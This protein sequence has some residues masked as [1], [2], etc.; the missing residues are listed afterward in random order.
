MKKIQEN[1]GNKKGSPHRLPSIELMK[2]RTN[3]TSNNR[4]DDTRRYRD[5]TIPSLYG[6]SSFYTNAFLMEWK[7]AV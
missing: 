2:K 5:A 4:Y 3:E 1:K 7:Y 6:L